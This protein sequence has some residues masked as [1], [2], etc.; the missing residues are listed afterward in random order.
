MIGSGVFMLPAVMAPYGS[1]SLLGWLFAG[2]GTLMIALMLGSLA[3]RIP[4]VGGPYTYVHR[5]LGDLPGFL[6]GWGHWISYWSATAVFGIA[7]AGY[8]GYLIPS[9][10]ETPLYGA[11]AA[12]AII[13]VMTAVNLVGVETVGI[14]QL[15]TTLLKLLPLFLISG[16]GLLLGDVTSIPANNPDN[17]SLPVL[18][19]GLVLLAMWSFVGIENVTISADDVIEPEKTIPRALIV[20]CL[21]ATVVYIIATVGVMA[22]I[23]AS[24]LAVS[25][26]PFADAA[27]LIFGGWGGALVAVGAIISIVG[28]LNGNILTSGMLARAIAL[29]KLLPERFAELNANGIPAFSVILA[30]V[31]ASVLVMMNYT[32]GLVAAFQMLI[33]L[34]TLTTLLP[35]AMSAIS[36]LIFQRKD[37]N[38][39]GDMSW[40]GIAMAI[41]ALVFSLFAIVGSGVEVAAYG[42]ILLAAGLPIY[43][44]MRH[45]G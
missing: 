36:A 4:S 15:V 10:G 12:V 34:S 9:L 7:F 16:G 22:L 11:L 29:D 42:L 31:L 27:A 17:E 30:G 18:I 8:L 23:P 20:G 39:G 5:A 45:R 19:A 21:T 44:W 13:W 14:V 26:S 33:L 6:V 37:A 38:A 35:Y 1:L 43:Y 2:T 24:E 3:R 25:S 28:A 41:G 40:K 32:R